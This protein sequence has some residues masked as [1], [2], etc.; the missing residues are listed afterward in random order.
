MMLF[1]MECRKIF[2]SMTYILYCLLV[3]LMIVS[4][5]FMEGGEKVYPPS[6]GDYDYGEKIVEDHDLIMSTAAD[7]LTVEFLSNR[8]VCYPFGFYKAVHLDNEEQSRIEKYISEITGLDRAG[9]EEKKKNSDI[10]YITD[11][12]HDYSE[13]EISDMP[14]SDNMTYERFKVIMEDVDDI[15]GGGSD[16]AVDGLIYKFSRVPMTYEDAVEDYNSIFTDDR[17]TNAYARLF[18]DYAGI[19][20]AILPVFVAAALTAADR[21]GRMSELVYSRRSSSLRIVSTRF[22]ALVTTMF[23]PVF[24]FMVIAFIQI[25]V[26]YSGADIDM[27]AMFTLPTFWLLPNIMAATAT[28]MLITEILSAGAAILV[29]F[30]WWFMGLM[31]GGTVGL[32]G[33][34]GK[35]TFI[36]RHNA[37]GKRN[38]FMMCWG[39]FVFDRIFYMVLS[40]AAVLLTVCIY[41]LKRGGSFNGIRLFG[42]GSIFR[43]KA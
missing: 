22:I 29:Q 9:I 21:R 6:K 40:I 28:G 26:R 1:R 23:I 33:R 3:I 38:E 18:S 11:G 34:I 7:A 20:L 12:T 2:R 13:Y 37:L 31:A 30:V 42:K 43:R 24:L 16:Y 17:V 10:C 19:V 5:Y 27:T 15:L 4:Q 39:N 25:L 36:C 14:I 41:E 35:Y 32:S 8:Y